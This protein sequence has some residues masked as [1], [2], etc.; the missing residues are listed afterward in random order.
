MP[1][2]IAVERGHDGRVLREVGEQFDVTDERLKDGST[3]F[4][5]LKDAPEPKAPLKNQRPPGA[6][7]SRGSAAKDA[8]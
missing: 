4:V 1:R 6:G 8:E 3:W 5:L 2:V 7:P